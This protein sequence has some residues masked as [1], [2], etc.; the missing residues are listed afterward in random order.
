MYRKATNLMLFQRCDVSTHRALI[1]EQNLSSERNSSSDVNKR[2]I[3]SFICCSRIS[4]TC[5]VVQTNWVVL[6][7]LKVLKI[8]A[9][10]CIKLV[11]R[12]QHLRLI[13]IQM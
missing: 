12:S 2:P 8:N 1:R 10:F 3:D 13:I 7:R 5:A 6:R 4:E 11:R 9:L